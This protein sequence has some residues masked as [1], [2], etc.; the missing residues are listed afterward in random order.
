VQIIFSDKNFALRHESKLGKQEAPE[1][2]MNGAIV[3]LDFFWTSTRV[4]SAYQKLSRFLLALHLRVCPSEH[5]PPINGK[6]EAKK[7]T[8]LAASVTVRV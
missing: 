2:S 8:R 3:L 5:L 6:S 7:E 4:R 1:G